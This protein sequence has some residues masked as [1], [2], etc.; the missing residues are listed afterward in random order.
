MFLSIILKCIRGAAKKLIAVAAGG[1]HRSS[2]TDPLTQSRNGPGKVATLLR[3]ARGFAVLC[4]AS[5]CRQSLAALEV[6]H[7]SELKKCPLWVI[8]DMPLSS[9]D[10]RFYLRKRISNLGAELFVQ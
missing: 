1:S 7:Q 5:R 9:C 6:E 10:V 2:R 8:V 3:G 4:E